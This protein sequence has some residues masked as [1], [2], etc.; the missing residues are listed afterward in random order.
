MKRKQNAHIAR[1][2][3]ANA[4]LN[5]PDTVFQHMSL[6]IFRRRQQM[7]DESINTRV[8]HECSGGMRSGEAERIDDNNCMLCT[9]MSI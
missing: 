3:D 2:V 5:A 6:K 1:R 7:I 9:S 8:F 4:L